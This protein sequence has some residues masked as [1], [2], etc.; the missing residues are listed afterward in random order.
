MSTF[1]DIGLE[2]VAGTPPSGQPGSGRPPRDLREAMGW[3]DE[4]EGLLRRGYQT[5]GLELL[6]STKASMRSLMGDPEPDFQP[7][8]FP[9]VFTSSPAVESAPVLDVT[10]AELRSRISG[11][12]QRRVP[13]LVSVD[14]AT[15]YEV[16][17]RLR[18]VPSVPSGRT[19]DVTT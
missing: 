13:L 3:L 2:P 7:A 9:V 5:A 19:V 15:T 11:L 16:L 6:A 1:P 10:G 18:F 4:A 8:T 14:H 17:S 12:L